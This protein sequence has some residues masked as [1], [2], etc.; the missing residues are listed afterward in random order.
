MNEKIHIPKDHPRY[1]S[2]ITREKLVN[3]F[4]KGL[5]ATEGLIA[6]GRGES[7]D[8]LLG[9]RTIEPA[10]RAINASSALF[11]LARYP[12]ISIN[13]NTAAL[14]AEEIC[15][16]NQALEK[17]SVEINLFYRIQNREKIIANELKSYGIQKILGVESKNMTEISELSSNRRKVDKDGIFKAD[18]VFVPLED[19]D[20]TI[21]LKKMNKKVVCVDL[22]PLS[23]TSIASDISIIDNIVR[24]VPQL[25]ERIE[26]NK[27]NCSE[28]EL[29]DIVNQ[30]DNVQVLKESLA[31]LRNSEV[32]SKT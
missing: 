6:H 7:F 10:L 31:L 15:K 1:V 9:E 22:N 5:V 2:L 30:Y 11:L 29:K 25:I 18:V 28:R 26:Y 16:L 21:A 3:G 27:R 20:R 32:L 12:V 17:S 23:R 14:C 4:K 19:G 24:V 8:Y 13:G